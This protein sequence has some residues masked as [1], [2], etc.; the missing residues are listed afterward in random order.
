MNCCLIQF[1]IVNIISASSVAIINSKCCLCV[2]PISNFFVDD[3]LY[4]VLT[5]ED[6]GQDLEGFQVSSLASVLLTYFPFG[7][8]VFM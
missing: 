8:C 6:A 5:F 1:L 7:L 4:V 3:Q 2:A